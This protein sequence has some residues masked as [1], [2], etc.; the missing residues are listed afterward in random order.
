MEETTQEGEAE[1]LMPKMTF[2]SVRN[3]G[4]ALPGLEE[5]TA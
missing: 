2:D 1:R 4:L 5:S 3:L